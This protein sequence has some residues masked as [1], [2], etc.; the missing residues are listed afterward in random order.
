[1]PVNSMT[2]FARV[3]GAT[4]GADFV[5]ELR[6]VNGKTLEV[7]LRLP[8]GFEGIEAEVRRIVGSRL[9]RGNVQVSLSVRRA[10]DEALPFVIHREMLDA[11]LRLSGELV[12]DGH[13]TLP[14][15]D[16]LLALRG[17]IDVAERVPSPEDDALRQRDILAALEDAVER[18]VVSRAGEGRQL[19]SILEDR[20]REIGR[21]VED[22]ENDPSRRMDVIRDRLA[23]QV[24]E[25]TEAAGSLDPARL[26]AE[27]AL[28]ATRADIREELDRLRA[29]LHAAHELLAQDAPIGRRFD[30]LAQEF[31]RE[32]NTVCSK[33][34]AASLTAIGLQLKVV[35]DQLREQV[36]NIE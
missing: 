22:A 34:N 4:A 5:W 9:G 15:A 31:N 10:A 7:R 11:V 35:V 28:I 8:P 12:R 27:A 14:S 33:S 3:E 29:H 16:G 20:L 19:Q 13:A 18:L 30:F 2:G 21:L 36:Q 26:H 17:V 24:A 23:R 32:S 6:S 1:M 25:L